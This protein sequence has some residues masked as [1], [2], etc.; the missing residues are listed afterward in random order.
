MLVVAPQSG[1]LLGMPSGV[2]DE[3]VIRAY[4]IRRALCQH[5][6]ELAEQAFAGTRRLHRPTLLRRFT[7]MAASQIR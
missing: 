7:P 6:G 5:L 1:Q 2:R 4:F 3:T